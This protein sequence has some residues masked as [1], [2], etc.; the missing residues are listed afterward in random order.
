M[1]QG[2]RRE[3]RLRG[4]VC[5]GKDFC[6]THWAMDVL[7]NLVENQACFKGWLLWPPFVVWSGAG[8]R[9][10]CPIIGEDFESLLK[11]TRWEVMSPKLRQTLEKWKMWAHIQEPLKNRSRRA[12]ERDWEQAV[13]EAGGVIGRVAQ[14]LLRS[15]RTGTWWVDT[16]TRGAA[17]SEQWEQETN[18]SGLRR[19]YS[20]I[21][22]V[23]S[24][25]FTVVARNKINVR[26]TEGAEEFCFGKSYRQK[27]ISRIW[28]KYHQAFYFYGW[29]HISTWQWVRLS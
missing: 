26:E 22:T 17:C 5:H 16:V 9:G 4:P 6:F 20:E 14:R 24:G 28:A 21:K 29:K 27:R 8:G 11:Q 10:L 3:V 1:R 13:K 23:L 25:S 12:H 15:S 19:K 7:S 18:C 2:W